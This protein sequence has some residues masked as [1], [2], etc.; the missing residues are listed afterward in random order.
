MRAK[1]IPFPFCEAF[2]AWFSTKKN[3]EL[4][5]TWRQIF[6]S[7]SECLGFSSSFAHSLIRH[8]PHSSSNFLR[9]F[10]VSSHLHS[11]TKR[12]FLLFHCVSRHRVGKRRKDR[13]VLSRTAK[14]FSWHVP[15]FGSLYIWNRLCQISCS[16]S[17]I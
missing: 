4:S 2:S 3:R 7:E 16:P 10:P 8:F 14:Y 15:I 6:R 17:I 13:S 1:W 9:F 12:F 5:S 11:A